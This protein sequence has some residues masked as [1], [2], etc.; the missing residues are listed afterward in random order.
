MDCHG[1]WW[2]CPT[3]QGF[4]S[5][6]AHGMD[7]ENALAA[8][9]ANA[10][11]GLPARLLDTAFFCKGTATHCLCGCPPPTHPLPLDSLLACFQSYAVWGRRGAERLRIPGIHCLKALGSRQ[12]SYMSTYQH[13]SSLPFT[14][15]THIPHPT[16]LD[17]RCFP[18]C[19]SS[20]SV[21]LATT[22]ATTFKAGGKVAFLPLSP[23]PAAF[24]PLLLSS[25]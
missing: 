24:I 2:T 25:H 20:T 11:Q 5:L 22:R 16:G 14:P 18:S 8:G 3:R 15:P 17:K 6:S 9:N 7:W 13:A 1:V 12:H 19:P 23:L 21:R 10:R 4:A